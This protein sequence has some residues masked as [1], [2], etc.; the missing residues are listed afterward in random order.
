MKDYFID[1]KNE[2]NVGSP[3]PPAKDIK[4]EQVYKILYPDSGEIN[5][6]TI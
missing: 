6:S 3:L 2:N 5:F 1:R 4:T